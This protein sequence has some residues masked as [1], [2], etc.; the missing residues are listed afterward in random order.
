MDYS[1]FVEFKPESGRGSGNGRNP[2]SKLYVTMKSTSMSFPRSVNRALNG[3]PHVK[4]MISEEEKKF[5]LIPVDIGLAFLK[6]GRDAEASVVW[7]N[8]DMLARIKALLPEDK[9]EGVRIYGKQHGDGIVFDCN[10]LG[11]MRRRS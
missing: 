7:H 5:A 6:S 10:D 8:K 4:L 2:S 11:N 3:A 1:K 9:K